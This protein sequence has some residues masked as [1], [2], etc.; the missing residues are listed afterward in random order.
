M[1][2]LYCLARTHLHSF[3]RRVYD[4][5]SA[6]IASRVE[7]HQSTFVGA[8]GP[9]VKGAIFL[10]STTTR[11]KA[12]R[13]RRAHVGGSEIMRC[14]LCAS[15]VA[16]VR[17]LANYTEPSVV[18]CDTDVLTVTCTPPVCLCVLHPTSTRASAASARGILFI[19]PLECAKTLHANE[20]RALNLKKNAPVSKCLLPPNALFLSSHVSYRPLA[21]LESS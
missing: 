17:L 4:S 8:R 19:S 5:N 6:P 16:E 1:T 7:A 13:C 21:H 12:T 20:N 10:L 11:R 9:R 18:I 2:A 3:Q 15:Q 14:N